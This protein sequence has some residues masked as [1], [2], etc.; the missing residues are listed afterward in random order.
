MGKIK[1]SQLAMFLNTGTKQAPA[2]SLI[3]EGVTEQTINYNPQ[4]SDETYIHQD[5]G[6]TDVESYK[7]TIPT[8]MTAIK[9]DAVFDHVDEIRRKR[10]VLGDARGEVL[11]VYLYDTAGDSYT[12]T[13]TEPGDWATKYTDY[14]TKAGNVY[15]P[16]TGGT[17]PAWAGDTYYKKT[18]GTSYPAERNDC[19]IQVD[20]FGGPGGESAK[21]NFTINL[22]G[23]PVVGTFDPTTKTFTEA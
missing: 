21:L 3:G 14:Y 7:P 23:D 12:L 18:A 8:P 11:I 20:D 17:A 10:K 9:G 4:T 5:S 2:W 16:V 6:T 13:L 1:R 15:S 22:I 19:S